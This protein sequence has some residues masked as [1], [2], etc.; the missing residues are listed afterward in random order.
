MHRRKVLVGVIVGA[1][2]IAPVAAAPAGAAKAKTTTKL[3]ATLSDANGCPDPAIRT[4]RV[5][6]SSP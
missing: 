4:A 6:P 3:T 5:R 1:A 2:S